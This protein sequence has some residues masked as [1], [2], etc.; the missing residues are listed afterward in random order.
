MTTD[1]P[2]SR[3][4]KRSPVSPAAHVLLGLLLDEPRSGYELAKVVERS[5]GHFWPIT[6]AHVY[7]E[8]PR[9]AEAGL[10][11]GSRIVQSSLPDKMV[12]EATE[13]GA[14]AFAEWLETSDLGEPRL[15]HPLLLKLFFASRLPAPVV[16]ALTATRRKEIGSVIA[17]YEERLATLPDASRRLTLR[18]GILRLRAELEFLDEVEATLPAHGE[19]GAHVKKK[20]KRDKGR[21]E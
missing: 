21:P 13:A 4:R 1:K 20:T 17:N 14:A 18:Y 11:V 10:A 3:S 2:T 5:V 12:F 9:L 16:A 6:K 15:H 19:S 7:V 8:L